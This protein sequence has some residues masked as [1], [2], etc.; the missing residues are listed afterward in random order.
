MGKLAMRSSLQGLGLAAALL[1]SIATN[2]P[3]LAEPAPAENSAIFKAAGFKKGARGDYVRC[4]EETPSAS[5]TPGR[6]E[7][8]DLNR[9]GQPEA[10]VT[11]GSLFCYGNT[12]EFFVLVTKDA[13]GWRTLIEST[14]IPRVLKTGHAG[15]P[16]IEVGGPGFVKFPV[17]RWNGKAYVLRR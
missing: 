3:L 12:A 4:I 7:L 2:S 6:I 14:G 11:E 1:C 10:W 9:D 17:Y 15:W 8:T 13:G 16:D 5:S